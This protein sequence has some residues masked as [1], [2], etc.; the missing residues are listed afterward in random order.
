MQ[1]RDG[2]VLENWFCRQFP[3]AQIGLATG[4]ASGVVVVDLDVKAGVD[5]I[6]NF[7]HLTG[8]RRMPATPTAATPTSG[9]HLFYQMPPGVTV[10]N[11]ASQ[12]AAGVDVRG[13]GGY[14]VLPPARGRRWLDG[15]DPWSTGMCPLPAFIPTIDAPPGPLPGTALPPPI[16][17]HDG[18]VTSFFGES[19]LTRACLAIEQA[20]DGC[21]EETLNREVFSIATL[22]AAGEIGRAV[23]LQCLTSSAGRMPSYDSHR[24]WRP[25]EIQHKLARAFSQGLRSP[26]RA[27]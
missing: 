1:G 4:A 21:Q 16:A 27:A 20:P 18:T 3:N 9:R 24:P 22:V 26:R 6:A 17:H 13:C 19:A 15:R 7:K 10:K 11:S 2:R 8:A 14:V 5:G 12:L 25:A 23:A